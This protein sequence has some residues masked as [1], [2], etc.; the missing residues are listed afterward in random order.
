MILSK[1]L[2]QE[3]PRGS[4]HGAGGRGRRGGSGGDARF[5]DYRG[6]V[7]RPPPQ[8][9]FVSRS[10]QTSGEQPDPGTAHDGQFRA[11][12]T[13]RGGAVAIPGAAAAAPGADPPPHRHYGQAARRAMRAGSGSGDAPA[14]TAPAAGAPRRMPS[15]DTLQGAGQRGQPVRSAW[16]HTSPG[17]RV[18][19]S[20]GMTSGRGAA[21]GLQMHQ[22]TPR[23]ARVPVLPL[24]TAFIGGDDYHYA[25]Q[26]PDAL[27]D[28]VY[29][30][31]YMP[32]FSGAATPGAAGDAAGGRALV[33]EVSERIRLASLADVHY[34]YQAPSREA[35]GP[36]GRPVSVQAAN[37]WSFAPRPNRRKLLKF[38]IGG[39]WTDIAA[40]P[41]GSMAC[42]VVGRD[43]L[44]THPMED[45]NG[46]TQLYNLSP[47]RW[48]LA[49]DMQCVLWRPSYHI[50]TGSSNG[51][52]MVW[53]PTSTGES[54]AQ[55]FSESLR[56]INRLAYK[57]DDARV[58][59]VA[60]T[61]GDI[62][63]WDTRTKGRRTTFNANTHASTQD[64]DC[65]PQDA[66]SLAA[67]TQEGVV[68]TWDIRN[69]K[70]EL[71]RIFAH[72]VSSGQCIAWH[73]SGRF[74]A[75]GGSEHVIKI[76]DLKATSTK[77]LSPSTYCSI[78]TLH[79]VH[80]VQ[81]RPGHDTQISSC[82]GVHDPLLQV[83][84]M[85]NPN[86]SFIYHD[87]HSS[88]IA[89]FTWHD[90]NT[91]WSVGL[92][93]QLVQCDMQSDAILT[94]GLLPHTVADFSPNT[95]I[96]V[97]TGEHDARHG[98]SLD[99]I[100]SQQ[101]YASNLRPAHEL[102]GRLG[103]GDSADNPPGAPLAAG[104]GSSSDPQQTTGVDTFLPNLPQPYV[105]EHVLDGSA[106]IK[107]D[108]V[109]FLSK[110]YRYDSGSLKGCCE[111]N[112]RAAIV[113]GLWDMAKF[114]QV[115]STVFGDARPL[116]S[117]RRQKAKPA[118]QGREQ[119][120]AAL[121]NMAS[122]P[123]VVATNTTTGVQSA[124]TSRSSSVM[125]VSKPVTS[126]VPRVGS[127]DDEPPAKGPDVRWQALASQGLAAVTPADVRQSLSTG[128]LD[129][130]GDGL[131]LR[132]AADLPLRAQA[133]WPGHS[134]GAGR[135]ERGFMSLSH[136]NLQ[137]AGGTGSRSRRRAHRAG[138]DDGTAASMH[139]AQQD[140]PDV[141]L[142]NLHR[143][144]LHRDDVLATGLL[145][146]ALGLSL[147]K[148]PTFAFGDTA[149]ATATAAAAVPAAGSAKQ[150]IEAQRR[151]SRADLKLALESCAYYANKGDVQTALTA[152]L[153]LRGFIRL[154]EWNAIKGWFVDYIDQLDLYQEHV[155]ATDIILAA[156]F[157]DIQ[158][159]L[160]T[161][162][163]IVLTCSRCG[164]KLEGDPNVGYIWCNDCNKAANW[165]VVCQL[166]VRGRYIWCKGCN[167]GGHADHMGEW[168]EEQGQQLCPAGCGH[169][170]QIGPIN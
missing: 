17:E 62:T 166:P 101:F 89:G 29:H 94:S 103:S 100:T 67:I 78:K 39:R 83:W 110:N 119:S 43:G 71:R 118:V 57:P 81:W 91:V 10:R 141:T 23:L 35:A 4:E 22:P 52:V 93:G 26:H 44:F 106:Q 82:A 56:R 129:I 151:V 105:D 154:S 160:S 31:Q 25:A 137:Q 21:H 45:A 79:I 40:A 61:N 116:K 13:G 159:Q 12:G 64:I 87:K 88:G 51:N 165:C 153:L 53:D 121:D 55:K 5:G 68:L 74:I 7:M 77:K 124:A 161:D 145:D 164:E 59:Y 147:S 123:T 162:T 6:A 156:P 169:K 120:D 16:V 69:P 11:A 138:I 157:D 102:A 33:D 50:V 163:S 140:D 15:R 109:K 97:A 122:Q 142:S 115:L 84:D 85:H 72:G 48:S 46:D 2:Y 36:A 114:W 32:T 134:A 152:A 92:R 75:S 37:P 132:D 24:Q 19:G 130:A 136:S 18:D 76:W 30:A 117:R 42:A 167:H 60:Y 70:K 146:A 133:V 125:F 170:C 65:N 38:T 95:R 54:L 80:R 149:A 155:V 144:Y 3:A 168:F 14:E 49:T 28:A 107:A 86:H 113:V 41:S 1:M 34:D 104:L 58:V 158:D 126:T 139:A 135:L 8:S 66:N 108:V 150:S 27:A 143:R 148:R 111:T 47:Q 127:S 131:G 112:S 9:V 90:K 73:P 20:G 96:C 98:R 128:P 63:G 99:W